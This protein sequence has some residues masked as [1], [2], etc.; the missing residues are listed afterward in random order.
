MGWMPY[1]IQHIS[2]LGS[3][4]LSHCCRQHARIKQTDTNKHELLKLIIRG[5]IYPTIALRERIQTV[6][7]SAWAVCAYMLRLLARLRSV[8]YGKQ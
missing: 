2:L 8:M 7:R 4:S 5:G 6:L 3:L 1:W